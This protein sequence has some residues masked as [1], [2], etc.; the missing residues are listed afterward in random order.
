VVSTPDDDL[1]ATLAGWRETEQA[2][3]PGP[4]EAVTDDHGRGRKLDHS[5]WADHAGYYFAE[6][7]LTRDDAEF[8][9]TARTAL[10]RLLAAVDAVLKLADGAKVYLSDMPA[11]CSG[12]CWVNPCD[13]SGVKPPVAWTL[14]PA[15]VRE[16]ITEALAGKE[17]PGA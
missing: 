15:K 9:A 5:V 12:A 1:T 11:D 14:D 4:L 16:A 7:V 6:T 17:S 2:A 3:T 10:P 13:C 8:I